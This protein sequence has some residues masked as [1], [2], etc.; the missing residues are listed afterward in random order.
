MESVLHLVSDKLFLDIVV[1]PY[2]IH[3]A[4]LFVYLLFSYNLLCLHSFVALKCVAA[5]LRLSLG[6]GVFSFS[7][8]NQ[9]LE[10]EI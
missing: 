9:E 6:F 5:W 7:H 10:I 3:F 1:I 2:V 4:I 8:V